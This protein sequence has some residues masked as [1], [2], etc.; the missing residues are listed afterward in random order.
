MKTLLVN[1]GLKRSSAENK[2]WV[3]KQNLHSTS[4]MPSLKKKTFWNVIPLTPPRKI[5]EVLFSVA[6]PGVKG[7]SVGWREAKHEKN[8]T[9]L[10]EG[11]RMAVSCLWSH[12]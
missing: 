11:K 4:S 5:G 10:A 2:S 8:P 3:V 7:Q 9:L 12:C 6:V 1:D